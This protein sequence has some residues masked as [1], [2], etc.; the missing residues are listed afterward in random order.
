M[1]VD[2]HHYHHNRHSLATTDA[3][4]MKMKWVRVVGDAM[5]GDLMP[6]SRNKKREEANAKEDGKDFWEVSAE[7]GMKI[8]SG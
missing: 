8:M 5:K 6:G 2:Q 1:T 3:S 7:N 4:K